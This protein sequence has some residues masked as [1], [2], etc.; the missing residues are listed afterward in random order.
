[1][2]LTSVEPRFC[3]GPEKRN[4]VRGISG[5]PPRH[6][7]AVNCCA[8]RMRQG[9]RWPLPGAIRNTP[10]S[11]RGYLFYWL[12]TWL[13]CAGPQM[14]AV[15]QDLPPSAPT[16]SSPGSTVSPGPMLDG[17]S[18]TLCWLPPS[19]GGPTY[20]AYRFAEVESGPGEPV[21]VGRILSYS[22]IVSP[23]R[24]YMWSVA[25]GNAAGLSPYSSTL[26]FQTQ[27]YFTV[28]VSA[29]P[30]S[31]GTVM[32]NGTYPSNFWYTVNA[33]A[34][35]GYAFVEWT[36]GETAVSASPRYRFLLTSNRTLVGH[37][38]AGPP[39]DP[40]ELT[41][42]HMTNGQ[43][44]FFLNGVP[45]SNYVV[46]VSSNL[47]SWNVLVTN[48]IPSGGM[49]LIAD[50]AETNRGGRFYRALR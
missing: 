2:A 20:Y 24:S 18:V 9:R 34:N 17:T 15:A 42:M 10:P 50:P 22:L 41:G 28:A 6:G 46:Q 4:D 47:G 38:L 27:P 36:E 1:M 5:K 13:W 40:G 25:A 33:T 19:V 7:H 49:T 16:A 29:S 11:G 31:G 3:I 44:R 35:S 32:G 21:I 45:S 12:L 26:Y 30:P 43:F 37:F 39:G 8:R 23:G 14:N 48:T